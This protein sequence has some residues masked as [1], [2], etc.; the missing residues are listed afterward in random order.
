MTWQTI[1]LVVW[2][3]AGAL[4]TIMAIGQERDPFTVEFAVIY[5]FVAAFQIWL[6]VSA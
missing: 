1:A 3:A 6:I 5:Q 2:A 4:I